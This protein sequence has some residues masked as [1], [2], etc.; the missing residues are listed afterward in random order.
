M[1][2][3]YAFAAEVINHISIEALRSRID[4]MVKKRLRGELSICENC[5]LHCSHP[6]KEIEFEIDLS[7]I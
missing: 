1:L 7:K 6:E 4:D 5:V 2:L 3:L